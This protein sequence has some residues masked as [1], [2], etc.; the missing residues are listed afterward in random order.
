MKSYIKILPLSLLM[1]TASCGKNFL[2]V[3]PDANLVV[4]VK[5]ED[6]QAM[7]D[8]TTTMNESS[9]VNIG[10]IGA[11]DYYVTSAQYNTAGATGAPDFQKNAYIWADQIYIGRETAA[12]DWNNG[13]SHILIANYAIEGTGKIQRTAA[14]QQQ[15]DNVRGSALF[16]RAYNFYLL[17]QLY[18][19]AYNAAT[20]DTDMG[21][22]LRL[23]SDPSTQVQRT[24]VQATYL[25]IINDLTEAEPLLPE[26]AAAMV[27]PGKAALYALFSR[28]YLQ[29][30]EY[31]KSKDYA[32]KCLQ[33]QDALI[34]F[35]TLSFTTANTFPA[36]GKGNVEVILLDNAASVI[37]NNN[38]FNADTVLLQGYAND[39]LRLKAY[40]LVNATTGRVTFK[41]SYKGN[42][43]YFSGLAT[44]EI[45]LNRAECLARLNDAG[46]ALNDLN[47][48][49]KARFTP[50]A[51]TELQ[52]EDAQEV[53][54]WVIAERRIELV[55][56][57]TRWPDLRRLNKEARYATT[58][59]R[60][61]DG[62]SYELRP[63]NINKWTW[64]L[65]VEAVQ[66]GGLTQ[67]PR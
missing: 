16:F 17:A 11:D 25:Q 32:D 44:D 15:W 6:F 67:N 40:F 37:M 14:N 65:P 1:V 2:D 38:Y 39:D 35:N 52:S 51:Y 53:L 47:K 36:N 9:P 10:M 23:E 62:V 43:S 29:M 59:K 4:P 41:G 50:A 46:G 21:L 49:R 58:L 30:G 28:V 45:Y 54:D 20:A 5:L 60:L 61:L 33:L 3:K 57:G 42:T 24:S 63:D 19:P 8:Y 7:L 18:C 31:E 48:L 56:R 26:T 12:L 22:S 27:R 13:Y 55:M 66:N 34:D 64:P